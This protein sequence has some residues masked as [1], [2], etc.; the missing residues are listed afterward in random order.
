LQASVNGAVLLERVCIDS[1]LW[2]IHRTPM[3]LWSSVR[4][5]CHKA[6][7]IHTL[8]N[9]TAPFTEACNKVLMNTFDISQYTQAY[10]IHAFPAT[11]FKKI[12]QI[13]FAVTA[14]NEEK[15][16]MQSNEGSNRLGLG[17]AASWVK[18][19]KGRGRTLQF[20]DRQLQTFIKTNTSAQH[21][22]FWPQIPPRWG[23]S[24]RLYF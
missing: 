22:N 10:N 16:I 18:R 20:S 15:S 3:L 21:F 24:N 14:R 8:S 7:S 17:P 23:I 5:I 9:S 12:R 6:L 1:A 11:P 13:I 2:Q 4:C 19:L